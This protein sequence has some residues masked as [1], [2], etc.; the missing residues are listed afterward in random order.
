[1]TVIVVMLALKAIKAHILAGIEGWKAQL[2]D[3]LKP[4]ADQVAV[5]LGNLIDGIDAAALAASLPGQ[6]VD[7]IKTGHG[8]ASPNPADLA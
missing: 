5:F 7:L 1:M 8:P 3:T 4:F 6:V 2:P